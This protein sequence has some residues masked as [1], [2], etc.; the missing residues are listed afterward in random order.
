MPAKLVGRS[1]SRESFQ[2]SVISKLLPGIFGEFG[3]ILGNLLASERK[4]P[5]E[6]FQTLKNIF[7]TLIMPEWEKCVYYKNVFWG[8]W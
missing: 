2:G 6:M 3:K 7:L 8:W 5:E 1:G 4:R